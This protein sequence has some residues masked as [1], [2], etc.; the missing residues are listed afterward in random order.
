MLAST[1]RS[2]AQSGLI[3]YSRNICLQVWIVRD[4]D[5][6]ISA[7][8]K[9]ILLKAWRGA[10]VSRKIRLPDFKTIST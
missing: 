8:V 4:A 9:V 5:F 10:G 6:E 3:S 2:E 7:K 1:V